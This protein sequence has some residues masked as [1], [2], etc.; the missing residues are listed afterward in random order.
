MASAQELP[1]NVLIHGGPIVVWSRLLAAET[2]ITSLGCTCTAWHRVVLKGDPASP[3]LQYGATMELKCSGMLINSL[4]GDLV[5]L[6]ACSTIS[7]SFCGVA[8]Y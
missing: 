2:H 3:V 8:A 1:E 6:E 4:I 5:N 7:G